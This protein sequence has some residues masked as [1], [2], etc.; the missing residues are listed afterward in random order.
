MRKQYGQKKRC[1]HHSP[2]LVITGGYHFSHAIGVWDDIDDAVIC[3]SC[4]AILFKGWWGWK[5]RVRRYYS[6]T[7]PFDDDVPF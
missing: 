2:A 3:T 7:P 6:L 1:R 4:G 5:E